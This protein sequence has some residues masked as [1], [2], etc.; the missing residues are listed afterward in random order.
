LANGAW[1]I[2]LL[3]RIPQPREWPVHAL[4]S[5]WWRPRFDGHLYPYCPPHATKPVELTKLLL[6]TVKEEW[7]FYVPENY[8]LKAVPLFLLS[9]KQKEFLLDQSAEMPLISSLP[10]VLSRFTMQYDA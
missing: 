1:A 9:G 8:K 7:E 6:V 4:V 10:Q 2:Q 3:G 5:Q